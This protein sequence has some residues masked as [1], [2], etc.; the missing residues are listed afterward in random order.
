M[1]RGFPKHIF[2]RCEIC[3]STGADYP[4]AQLTPADSTS[5]LNVPGNGVELKWYKGKLVCPTCKDWLDDQ[6]WS[7]KERV[8][9]RDSEQFRAKAGFK[10]TVT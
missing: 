4:E 3:G 8:L 2:G 6:D 7:K 10:K 5:D 9:H 1:A